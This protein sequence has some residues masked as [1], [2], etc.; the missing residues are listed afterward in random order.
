MS[1]QIA[2]TEPP[3][4]GNAD[5]DRYLLELHNRLFGL[6]SDTSGDL[7]NDNGVLQVG[8]NSDAIAEGATNLYATNE[9]ID[10]RVAAL[11]QNGEA[12]TWAY[13][14]EA[15]T[16]TGEVTKGATVSDANAST[17]SVTSADADATYGTEER[18]LINEMKGD[19]NTLVT[20]L[21]SAITQ[22]NALMANL[23]TAKLLAI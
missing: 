8:T 19:I 14:D 12:L 18:D 9:R 13:N 22:Y 10:D 3:I 15:D 11:I 21:N 5:L 2:Y 7:D 4:T 16:L 1:P 6:G 23:R 17:V 20:D